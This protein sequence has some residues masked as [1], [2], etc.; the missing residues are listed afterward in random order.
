[1]RPSPPMG[2]TGESEYSPEDAG[3]G[4]AAGTVRVS[5][6]GPNAS[7][8]TTSP[9][10]PY[11]QPTSAAGAS[12]SAVPVDRRWPELAAGEP[13]PQAAPWPQINRRLGAGSR[14]RDIRP[15]RPSPP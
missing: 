9:M 7:G 1:M 6:A 3:D 4:A 2:T 13:G 10:A 11:A 5:P 14:V 15:G 8:F 12:L